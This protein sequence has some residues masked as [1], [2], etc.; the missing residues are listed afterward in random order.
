[1][2]IP[3]AILLKPSELS[4]E[5]WVIMR[6]HP[7]Y[8]YEWLSQIQYLSAALDIPYCHHERWDGTGYPRGLRGKQIPLAARLFAT[9]DV[10]DALSHHRPYRGAWP[11]EQVLRHIRM[12]TGTH[13]DPEAV[14]LFLRVTS[15]RAERDASIGERYL[16]IGA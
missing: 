8:A 10:W 6:K 16:P 14:E 3:D 11:E 1:M 2:G 9:V 7:T 5:E 12:R 15:E 13:F 4:E